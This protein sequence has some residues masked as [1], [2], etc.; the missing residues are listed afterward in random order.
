M[1]AGAETAL[2]LGPA[3]IER[4]ILSLAGRLLDRIEDVSGIELLSYRPSGRGKAHSGLVAVRIPGIPAAAVV[5]ELIRRERVLVREVP[6][7]PP[8]VRISLHYLNFAEEVDRVAEVL[9]RLC[10]RAART[11]RKEHAIRR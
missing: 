7:Y 10:A 9:E 8:G 4:R 1:A 5:D 11:G 6:A 3:S 2:R